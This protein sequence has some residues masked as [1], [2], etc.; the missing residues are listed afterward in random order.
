MGERGR[1]L[2]GRIDNSNSRNSKEGMLRR[3][4]VVTLAMRVMMIRIWL[5]G[6]LLFC[7]V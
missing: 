6:S 4:I 5:S 7:F 2:G 1:G 3:M